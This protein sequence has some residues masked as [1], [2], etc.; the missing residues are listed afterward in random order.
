M[1]KRISRHPRRG[2]ITAAVVLVSA[3]ALLTAMTPSDARVSSGGEPGG[4]RRGGEKLL[5]KSSFPGEPIQIVK[6]KNKKRDIPVGKKFE[7]ADAEWLR[8]FTI[9]IRND[10]GRDIT[11]LSFAILFPADKNQA[12]SE[13]SYTFDFMLWV[14]PQSKHYKESRRQRPERVIRPNEKYDLTLSD[15][16][17]EHIQKVLRSLGYPSLR[18]IEIWIDE[19]GFDD[20]TSWRGGQIIHPEGR[21]GKNNLPSGGDGASSFFL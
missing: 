16:Q 4:A 6:V 2:L 21:S 5:T 13:V 15:E 18:E 17:Y 8:G 12:S 11:H 10:S 20:A 7:E 3:G 14:S 9:T 19:V 1:K